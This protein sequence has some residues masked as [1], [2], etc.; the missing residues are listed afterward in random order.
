MDLEYAQASIKLD[1]YIDNTD[2][3]SNGNYFHIS[4]PPS[5]LL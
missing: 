4:G 1:D 2:C 3:L 5:S